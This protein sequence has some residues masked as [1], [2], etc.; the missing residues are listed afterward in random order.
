MAVKNTFIY[1]STVLIWGSTWLAIEFQLGEVAVEASLFYRFA[2][3]A[4]LM[5]LFCWL[6]G[7]PMAF[8]ARQHGFFALLA[9]GNFGINYLLLYW[10]QM[11]LTSAMASIA[12]STLLLM[13]IV[14]T[15]LFFGKKIE[16]KVYV[17]ALIGIGGIL[18]LYWQ[19]LQQ[20]SFSSDA[21]IGL[22]LALAG[23]FS[24]SL[25]NMVSVRNSNQGI[26]IFAGNAWG[27]SY[28][29]LL[30]LAILSLSGIEFDFSFEP[31]YWLSL[32][33]LVVFGTLIAFACYFS[34]LKN[35]GAEKASYLILLFPIVA[36]ILSSLFEGFVWH[37]H[38]VLGFL[39]V[40]MGNA[41]VLVPWHK[42][43]VVGR[44]QKVRTKAC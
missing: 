36:V 23:T 35:I 19:D 31:A 29:A 33:Y 42:V 34:L 30:M 38:T 10:A 1:L 37:Q 7:I 4:G 41:I 27:M 20:M 28:G 39:M 40:L 44:W 17:G 18:L 5:W 9:A 6:K 12:F 22:G 26:N 11:Y 43:N 13:N 3:S 15:R 21:L 14:N 16:I 8:N 25:G 24:A 32:G 2:L